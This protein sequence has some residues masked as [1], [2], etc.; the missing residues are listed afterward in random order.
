M[1]TMKFAMPTKIFFG[2]NCIRE[3]HDI[4]TLGKK[5]LLVT[6]RHSAKINGSQ[7]DVEAVLRGNHI[8]YAVFNEV[9]SNPDIPTVYKGAAAAKAEGADFIIAIG[10]GSPMDA[11]KG[12]ALL[13]CQDI[14]ENDLFSGTYAE[15]VLPMIH[16]PTTS[17]TGSEVTPYSILSNHL[18]QTKSTIATPL[19]FP[20]YALLDPAYQKNL[21]VSITVNTALDAL[22]HNIE[23]ALSIKINPLIGQIAQSGIKQIGECLPALAEGGFTEE[24]RAKLMYGSLAG[25]LCI[26]HTGTNIVHSLGYSLTYF[27]NI[28]H[29]R[30]NALTIASYLHFIAAGAP[31]KVSSI[32]SAM[33]FN[34]IEQFRQYIDQIL[35]KK[36]DFTVSELQKYTQIALKA[37]NINTSLIAPD[38]SAVMGF[39]TDSLLR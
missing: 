37:K 14:A 8:P 31:E 38:E 36:E 11:A 30:A 18:A 22:S 2:K 20:A 15:K 23:S 24:I 28:D 25:G 33:Q 39:Y 1:Q 10:G 3:H 9:D 35:G 16:I 21:P 32:L 34:N 4:F 29:G 13:A 12:I 7:D 19:I 17:G 27:R 6:G 5:A 26:A